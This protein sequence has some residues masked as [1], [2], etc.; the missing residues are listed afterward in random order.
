V[1]THFTEDHWVVRAEAHA[2]APEVV[3][4]IVVFI[5]PPGVRF[6]PGN[7]ETPTLGGMAPGDMQGILPDGDAKRVP[8]GA[9]L[10]FQMHY[11]PNGKKQS[12]RSSIGV[13]FARR[14]PK[15][16]VVAEPV[17]NAL[18]RI[19]PNAANYQVESFYT[20][21]KDGAI[22]G[23]MPHMHLRGKDFQYE[24]IYPDGKKE[25]LLSVPRFN[26]NWQTIYR[27]VRPLPMPRGTRLHCVAHFDNSANNPNNPDPTR[28]VMWGDQT[29]EEMMIGWTDFAFDLPQK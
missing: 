22:V 7:P 29:W 4:H 19:P 28:F 9:R 16:Y 5:V 14:P 26:F 11:T 23:F 15:Q 1:D 25:I 2:G 24:A 18:F 8:K 13:I 10:A 21:K 17:F 3:H 20:L 6:F 27:P 12:D